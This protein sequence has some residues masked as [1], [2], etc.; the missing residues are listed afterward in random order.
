MK[1]A[2]DKILLPEAEIRERV[3]E[4]GADITAAYAGAEPPLFVCAVLKGSVVFFSDLVRCIELPLCFDFLSVSSYGDGA[5]SSGQVR[6]LKDI[7]CNIEGKH[8]LLIEDI[9]DTGI[10]LNTVREMM[11]ARRPASLKICALLDKPSRRQAAITADF[12]GFTIPDEFI[13]GYGLDYGEK[14]RNLKDI[15]VL[16][17]EVFGG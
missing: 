17:K 3:A 5:E 1:D 6:I 12:I 9:V 4:L 16:K 13:V 10:T 11:L 8:L 2:I 15:C 14:Y 7:Q